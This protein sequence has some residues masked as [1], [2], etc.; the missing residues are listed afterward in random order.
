[1]QHFELTRLAHQSIVTAK[2]QRKTRF[3]F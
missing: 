2:D 3:A 1:M